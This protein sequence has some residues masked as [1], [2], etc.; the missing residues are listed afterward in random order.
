MG[1]GFAKKWKCEQQLIADKGFIARDDISTNT[2]HLL[3][4]SLVYYLLRR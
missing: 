2:G 4:V 3:I 1:V